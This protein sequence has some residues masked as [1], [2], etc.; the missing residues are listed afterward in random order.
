M[1]E[2]TI[3]NIRDLRL[4]QLYEWPEWWVYVGHESTRRRGRKQVHLAASPLANPYQIGLV[5]PRGCGSNRVALTRKTAVEEFR[6][7]LTERIAWEAVTGYVA[8]RRFAVTIP[9]ELRRH[10][11]LLAAHN[12][13]LYICWCGSEHLEGACWCGETHEKAYRTGKWPCHAEVLRDVLLEGTPQTAR[14]MGFVR[15]TPEYKPTG[16]TAADCDEAFG[17]ALS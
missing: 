11:T 7:Y 13:L 8:G 14:S 6:K 5:V 16:L 1:S 15:G 2:I 12:R 17:D 4:R 3:V 10:R 9:E